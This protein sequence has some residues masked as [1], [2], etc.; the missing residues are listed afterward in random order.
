MSAADLTARERSELCDLML[1]LGPDA[2]TLDT[3]WTVIDLAA[4]LVAREH[5]IW[6]TPGLVWGGAFAAVM[7]VARKRRRRKSLDKLVGAMRN[8]PPIWWRPVPAGLQ[9][10]EYYVH[11]EDVRRANGRGPRTDRPDLDRTLT[12]LV[13]NSA[14][15]YLRNVP[16]GVELVVEGETIYTHGPEPRARLDGPPGDLVLY[17]TG[18]R[19]AAQVSLGGDPGAA[20]TLAE[21]PLAI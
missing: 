5:D 20:S 11:H 6:A 15:A 1:E 10:H 21:A 14:G 13:R 9:L 4:H 16:V 12:R 18:R 19:S 3:G 8:G 2:P 7:E 17:L